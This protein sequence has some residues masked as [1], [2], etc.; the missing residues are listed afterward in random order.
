[1][2]KAYIGIDSIFV[3]FLWDQE[4]LAILDPDSYLNLVEVPDELIEEYIK[5]TQALSKV[6][7]KL[8]VL[9]RLEKSNE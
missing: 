2:A 5:L 8:G 1:M 6:Y 7:D 3:P 4:A 9:Y